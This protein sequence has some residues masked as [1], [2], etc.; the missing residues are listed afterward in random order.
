MIEGSRPRLL[1]FRTLL[2]VWENGHPRRCGDANGGPGEH[3]A[4]VVRNETDLEE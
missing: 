3:V 4:R 1:G 2:P